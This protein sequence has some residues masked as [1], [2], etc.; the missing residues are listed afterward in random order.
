MIT[1][2]ED[3]A[4]RGKGSALICVA[5]RRLIPQNYLARSSILPVLTRGAAF[6]YNGDKG[7]VPMSSLQ[8][9]AKLAGVSTSLVS[10]YINGQTGV[11]QKSRTKIAH[12]MKELN[13]EPNAIA[14]SLVTRRTKTI[15]IVM[16]TLCEP[17]FSID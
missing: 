15:R 14:R 4:S 1:T 8:E 12:A 11:S 16:D 7:V 17:Y 3:C 2:A 13:Y 5:L 10:R 6:W 9:V